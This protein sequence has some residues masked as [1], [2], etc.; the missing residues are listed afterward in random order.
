AMDRAAASRAGV[1]AAYTRASF[2]PS[3]VTPTRPAISLLGRVP[4]SA[5]GPAPSR[6]AAAVTADPRAISYGFGVPL[7]ERLAVARPTSAGLVSERRRGVAADP[8]HGVPQ[9]DDRTVPRW[10]AL[11]PGGAERGAPGTVR[12]RRE[13]GGTR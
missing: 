10:I 13:C 3:L 5:G 11:P 6:E 8:T 9:T 2:M 4:A 12:R 1:S 7:R